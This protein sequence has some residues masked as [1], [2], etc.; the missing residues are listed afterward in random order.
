[1]IRNKRQRYPPTVTDY[2]LYKGVIDGY[3]NEPMPMSHRLNRLLFESLNLGIDMVVDNLNPKLPRCNVNFM[4]PSIHL[5][6]HNIKDDT[7]K[8]GYSFTYVSRGKTEFKSVIKNF[9]SFSHL[10]FT[11]EENEKRYY[12]GFIRFI[13]LFVKSFYSAK[14]QKQWYKSLPG[15]LGNSSVAEA[16]MD[17]LSELPDDLLITDDRL[18]HS[19]N[20]FVG[21]VFVYKVLGGGEYTENKLCT[22]LTQ[23]IQNDT[24]KNKHKVS[25]HNLSEFGQHFYDNIHFKTFKELLLYSRIDINISIRNFRH[26]LLRAVIVT[27]IISNISNFDLYNNIFYSMFK[28][29]VPE[30]MFTNIHQ[31]FHASMGIKKGFVSLS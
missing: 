30:K 11:P 13:H 29:D 3:C 15:R 19:L 27:Q 26:P 22:R 10:Y 6:I 9:V 5:K 2:N 12:N 17:L 21:Q 1:M 28:D 4:T 20:R 8:E 14:K 23:K 18:L 25:S 7:T 24:F 16:W 31:I